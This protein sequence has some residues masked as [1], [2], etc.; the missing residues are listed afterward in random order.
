MLGESWQRRNNKELISVFL[1]KGLADSDEWGVDSIEQ[2]EIYQK[3]SLVLVKYTFER[4]A[5][6]VS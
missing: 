2:V 3:V 4:M 6:D 1:I 5:A